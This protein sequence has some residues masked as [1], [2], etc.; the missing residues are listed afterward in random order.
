MTMS[1]VMNNRHNTAYIGMGN[2]DAA[3]LSTVQKPTI[4]YSQFTTA[5]EA[6][7]NTTEAT[8]VTTD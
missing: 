8:H 5:T 2:N 6:L 7:L 4:K 1:I 3:T